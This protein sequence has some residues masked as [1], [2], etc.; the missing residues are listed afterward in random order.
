[1]FDDCLGKLFDR[2]S[3]QQATEGPETETVEFPEKI[4]PYMASN[5]RKNLS[6]TSFEEILSTY[7]TLLYPTTYCK[8]LTVHDY[9]AYY[10]SGLVPRHPTVN[11][12][13]SHVG[14]SVNPP[15][16]TGHSF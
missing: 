16:Q 11:H 8:P 1:M 5:L 3:C 10:L 9:H 4:Y 14:T 12:A 2:N 6:E 13:L 7:C 15:P